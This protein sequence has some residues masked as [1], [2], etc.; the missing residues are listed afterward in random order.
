MKTLA[1]AMTLS[2]IASA[3]YAADEEPICADRPGLGTPTCTVPAGMVQIE[4]GLVDWV[5]DRST[6]YR[7][8]QLTIGATAIKFGVTNRFHIEFDVTP[9]ARSLTHEMGGRETLSGFGDVGIA[10]RYRV[11]G[12]DSPIQLA[13]YPFVKVPTAKR[14]LGNGK[15]EGGIVVPVEYSIPGSQL[16]LG[17]SPE[18]DLVADS[19]GSGHHLGMAQVVGLSFALAERLGAAAELAG[20]WDWG[21]G[22]TVRQYVFGSSAAYLLSSH[23]QIDAGLTLGLNRNA[24]DIEIYSGLTVRF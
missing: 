11:S 16:S 22:G 2:C 5:H 21:P 20:E 7:S 1:L 12:E 23:A 6:G 10:A 19:D 17:F 15:V 24:P 4:T 3:A 18:L 14:P 8:D 9:I 13:L